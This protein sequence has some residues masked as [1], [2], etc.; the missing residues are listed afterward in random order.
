MTRDE[1]VEATAEAARTAERLASHLDRLA[2]RI[3]PWFPLEGEAI[4]AWDDDRHERLHALLRMFDQLYDITTRKLV[5]GALILS[6]ESL[7]GLSAQN[8]FRRLEAI[9]GLESAD[10][11]LEL[12]AIRNVLA[13]DYPT[14]PTAQAERANRVWF[15]VPALIEDAEGVLSYLRLEVLRP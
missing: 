5:R 9:G 14:N 3:A 1:V 15:E 10:R 6:G 13:H 8:Q 12:G 2:T 11:W 4:D 7:A